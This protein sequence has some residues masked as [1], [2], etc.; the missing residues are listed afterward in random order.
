MSQYLHSLQIPFQRAPKPKIN[1]LFLAILWKHMVATGD[2]LLPISELPKVLCLAPSIIYYNSLWTIYLISY[3][4]ANSLYDFGTSRNR[5]YK[6]GNYPLLPKHTPHATP[7]DYPGQYLQ[8][9]KE[10]DGIFRSVFNDKSYSIFNVTCDTSA[11]YKE[12]N[13]IKVPLEDESSIKIRCR[14]LLL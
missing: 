7:L 3:G 5:K 10:R 9:S 11:S 14:R 4:T 1:T 12:M 8:F 2:L 13:D 6:D